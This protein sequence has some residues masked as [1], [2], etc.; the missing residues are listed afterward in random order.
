MPG[1]LEKR[2][3]R[4][5]SS[6]GMYWSKRAAPTMT[7]SDGEAVAERDPPL[8]PGQAVM[9]SELIIEKIYVRTERRIVGNDRFSVIKFGCKVTT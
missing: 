1:W 6:R 3:I 7:E 8:L 2:A 4:L 5:P 9:I